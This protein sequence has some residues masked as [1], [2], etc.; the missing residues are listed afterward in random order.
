MKL[1]LEYLPW[2]LLAVFVA[3]GWT[4]E[5]NPDPEAWMGVYSP[6]AISSVFFAV[7][8]LIE[9]DK[10]NEAVRLLDPDIRRNSL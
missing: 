4:M 2:G 9:R 3:I 10:K 8:W 7:M 5:G 6:T 1:K